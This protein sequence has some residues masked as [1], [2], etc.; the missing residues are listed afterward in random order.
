MFPSAYRPPI[1]R[2]WSGITTLPEPYFQPFRMK[3]N[4]HGRDWCHRTSVP[5]R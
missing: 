4:I 1:S 3:R 5:S 2:I